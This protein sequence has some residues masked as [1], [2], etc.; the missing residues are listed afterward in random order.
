LI[1]EYIEENYIK[2]SLTEEKNIILIHIINW[3]AHG[4]R[5]C[6]LRIPL[7]CYDEYLWFSKY[8]NILN[9]YALE[10]NFMFRFQPYSVISQTKSGNCIPRIT[11]VNQKGQWWNTDS[12]WAVIYNR[13]N[14]FIDVNLLCNI[15]WRSFIKFYIEHVHST[16]PAKGIFRYILTFNNNINVRLSA[17]F[18]Y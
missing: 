7:Q 5:N 2:L 6:E 10:F 3:L 8:I 18:L 16:A 11:R 9:V 12:R 13:T 17:L 4:Q 14:A 1:G 15:R